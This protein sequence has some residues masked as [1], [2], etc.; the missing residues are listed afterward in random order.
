M[1]YGPLSD[2]ETVVFVDAR[3]RRYLKRLKQGHRITIRGTVIR[4]DDLLGAPE[5]GVA[6]RGEAETFHVFRPTYPELVE[7]MP[8]A[9]E[10]V[11]GKDVGSILVRGD[12]RAGDRVIEV[13]VGA[14]ALT[15]ALLRAIGP[16][17]VLTTYE[18]REDLATS[19][20]RAVADH[21]GEAPNW[22][23]KLRDAR[24]GFDETEVDR[25]VSD[26]PEPGTLLEG[27]AASLRPGG[28]F[29]AYVPTVLQI[30]E[31]HDRL[32]ERDDFATAETYELLERRWHVDRRSVRPDHRMVAHTGFLTFVRRT[33]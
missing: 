29:V 24:R 13:G 14:G 7:N 22:T 16:D 23:L 21:H 33:A 2:G 28:M 15:I 25:V 6:G 5:G 10:P 19:A 11:F 4:C 3:R 26:M 17:G 27:V 9:A 1:A 12:V 18:L 32:A 31:L 8:R 30:K 20:K